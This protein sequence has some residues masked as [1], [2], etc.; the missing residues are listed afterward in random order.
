MTEPE[1]RNGP[2]REGEERPVFDPAAPNTD[3]ADAP[4]PPPNPDV[5]QTNPAL[6]E[7]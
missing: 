7:E 4:V 5:P 2:E 1:Y 3:P 6:D